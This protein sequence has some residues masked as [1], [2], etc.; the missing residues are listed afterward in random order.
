M[1]LYVREDGRSMFRT[2]G[3]RVPGVV[4]RLE[5]IR[6]YRT[7]YDV[8]VEVGAQRVARE[9]LRR[10]LAARVCMQQDSFAMSE[11]DYLADECD[12]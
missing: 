9:V 12:G 11:S 1:M 3:A 8:M 6:G 2:P 4:F 7:T 5:R 10:L